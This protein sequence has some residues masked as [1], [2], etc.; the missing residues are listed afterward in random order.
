MFG[1]K[2]SSKKELEVEKQKPKE[3]KKSFYI[4]KVLFIIFIVVLVYVIINFVKIFQGENINIYEV[5]SGE[6]VNVDRHKGIIYRNEV[7]ETCNTDGHINFYVPNTKRVNRG[8][9]IYTINDEKNE[10]G[11]YDLT[12]EDKTKIN[13]NVKMYTSNITD[14][15]FSN[16]YNAKDR[17]TSQINELNLVKQLENVDVNNELNAK[18]K[19]FAR[20]AGLI[21]FIIDGHENDDIKS[22]NDAKIKSYDNLRVATQKKEVLSGDTIYKIV[23]SPEFY[24]A[25]DSNFD[26]DGFSKKNAVYVNFVYENVTARGEISSFI[27]EDDK[28]HFCLKVTEYPERFLDKRVVDFEIENK[29]I[30]GLK[31]PIKSIISKNCY[32]VPKNMIEKDVETDEN[33]L[34]KLG[35]N[36]E[37]VMTTCN[38]SKEDDSNYYISIDDTLSNIKYGDV[39]VNRYN[40]T[41]SL[42]EIRKLDGVYNMNKGY[43]IFKNVDIIDRTNEYAI[44]KSKSINGV[45]LYDHIA[46]DASR[47]E[48][49]DLI[50]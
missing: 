22:F 5:T 20:Y 26:Y 21:S 19:G 28:K 45:S 43:A 23:T 44:I 18:E 3:K 35:L 50:A 46:L 30:S 49:G 2:K 27:G 36:G 40:D 1:K 29:K 31:I 12:Y 16:I 11:S 6:I 39:I 37:R 33:I 4:L 9:F 25:F 48:E 7:V 10:Y 38:I 34:Y 17:I 32:I 15:D 24:I 41:Y 14:Y 13:Q 8:A 42:S 47:I